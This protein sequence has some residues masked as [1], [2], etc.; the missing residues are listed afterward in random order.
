MK[1]RD[2]GMDVSNHR[3]LDGVAGKPSAV[4][5][6]VFAGVRNE[7]RAC[8][9]LGTHLGQ[10]G[11][12]V[13]VGT[14][15]QLRQLHLPEG[16]VFILPHL[17]L[18]K[19]D[20]ALVGPDWGEAEAATPPETIESLRSRPTVMERDIPVAIVPMVKRDG[21]LPC[22]RAY[23][24]KLGCTPKVRGL[25]GRL[26]CYANGSSSRHEMQVVENYLLHG[27]LSVDLRGAE[28]GR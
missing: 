17:G 20:R 22:A 25:G 16:R 11:R 27:N 23:A 7:Q 5:G 2:A 28:T 18:H 8:A 9:D 12:D 26:P 10:H 15:R 6:S 4:A 21:H 14:L 24:K 3:Y 1:G 13:A 19:L